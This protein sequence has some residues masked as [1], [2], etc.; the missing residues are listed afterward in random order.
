MRGMWEHFTIEKRWARTVLEDADKASL[1]GSDEKWQLEAPYKEEPELLTH[2]TDLSF[3]GLLMS[4]SYHA[5]KSGDWAMFLENDKLSAWSSVTV[6]E[7]HCK[8]EEEYGRRRIAQQI[9]YNSI[10]VLR[11]SIV[12]VEGQVG[13]TL[14]YVCPHCHHFPI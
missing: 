13:I 4:Q 1:S 10:D 11:R 8:V 5:G 6:R 12:P 3:D 9:L 2:S 14:S 7:C